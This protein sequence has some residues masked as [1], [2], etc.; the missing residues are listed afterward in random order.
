MTREFASG[1]S[2]GGMQTYQLGVDLSKRLAAI[3]PEF[4]SFHRGFAMA[5]AVGV[6][7]LDLHGSQVGTLTLTPTRTCARAH[8]HAHSNTRTQ[9][10]TLTRARK[11]THAHTHTSTL[12]RAHTHTRS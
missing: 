12:T 9:T 2:N 4:G 6:P 3:F 10:H 11:H 8:V 5:P 7:V 1:E